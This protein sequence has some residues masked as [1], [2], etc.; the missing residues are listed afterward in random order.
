M[1]FVC[2]T[3]MGSFFKYPV[4]NTINYIFIPSIHIHM[5]IV[6]G[7]RLALWSSILLASPCQSRAFRSLCITRHIISISYCLRSFN[8]QSHTNIIANG[9][10]CPIAS[11]ID[12][13]P[14]T[15]I[16]KINGF[17]VGICGIN[18]RRETVTFPFMIII[19]SLRIY[20]GKQSQEKDKHNNSLYN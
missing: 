14:S 18:Y 16:I 8:T 7:I 6:Y 19:L 4:D 9:H 13:L 20:L 15:N 10:C 11:S 17:H 1:Y 3:S 5:I 12:K 2:L